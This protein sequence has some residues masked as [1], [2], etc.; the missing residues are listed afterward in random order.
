ML[1]GLVLPLFL[2]VVAPIFGPVLA[3]LGATSVAVLLPAS[4]P[5]SRTEGRLFASA[6]ASKHRY[7]VEIALAPDCGGADACRLGDVTG[8]TTREQPGGRAV[9]L[10]DGTPAYFIASTCGASCGDGTL[11]WRRGPSWYTV[12]IKAGSL[13]DLEA[14]ANAMVRP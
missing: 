13:H 5:E 12:G 9:K 2:A 10:R 3:P 11:A 4:I 1:L 8:S 7:H 14:W 6:T